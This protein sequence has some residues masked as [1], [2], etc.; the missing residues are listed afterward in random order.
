MCPVYLHKFFFIII[1]LSL[2]TTACSSQD[3]NSLELKEM[4][5]VLKIFDSKT[6]SSLDYVESKRTF[7]FYEHIRDSLIQECKLILEDIHPEGIYIIDKNDGLS[8]NIISVNNGSVF[9][10][11]KF[12]NGIRRGKSTNKFTKNSI[13]IESREDVQKFIFLFQ[14]FIHNNSNK[15]MDNDSDNTIVA[16]PITK[17]RN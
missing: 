2:T 11:T 8:L 9:A 12:V 17:S 6:V 1:V 3:S 14:R 4:N 10:N 7:I 16:P 15:K 5:E 13:N